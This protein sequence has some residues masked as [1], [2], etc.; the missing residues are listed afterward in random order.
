MRERERERE[1]ESR[2]ASKRNV[3]REG[4]V[5]GRG[6]QPERS[7]EFPFTSVDKTA[8][9]PLLPSRPMLADGRLL[10]GAKSEAARTELM[11]N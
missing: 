10:Q 7:S 1:R 8:E 6:G 5:R 4:E 11:P 2:I 3:G 9:K